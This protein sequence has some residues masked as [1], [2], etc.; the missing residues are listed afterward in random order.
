MAEPLLVKR[1]IKK[2]LSDKL[3]AER[4]RLLYVAAT[5]AID[6]LVL[7]GHTRLSSERVMQ[8]VQY[9]PMDQLNNWMDW[10]NKILGLSF[11]ATKSRGEILYGDS[12]ENPFRIPYRKFTFDRV[13][14]GV[15]KAY[16]TEFPGFWS[17]WM[18]L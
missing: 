14:L 2:R 17:E 4:N 13:H 1:I 9:A 7:V 12:S 16:R 10:M 8:R 3:I 18:C 5:R 6:H 15:E 11:Q